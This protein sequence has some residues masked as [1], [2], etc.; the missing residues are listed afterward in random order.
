MRSSLKARIRS[1]GYAAQGIATLLRTEPNARLHLGA[2]LAVVATGLWLH[3][4]AVDWR[5]LGLAVALVWMAEALNTAIEGLCDLV[6]PGFHPQIKRIKDVA[7]GGVLIAALGAVWIG[8]SVFLP[9]L[10]P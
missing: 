7:A 10:L 3:V 8:G 6:H 4:A 2:T 1:I 5:W 9:Y